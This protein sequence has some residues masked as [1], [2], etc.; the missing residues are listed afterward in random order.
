[1]FCQNLVGLYFANS[2][3]CPPQINKTARMAMGK[4][5]QN[6]NICTLRRSLSFKNSQNGHGQKWA[7]LPIF[8]TPENSK[9]PEWAWAYLHFSRVI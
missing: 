8:A 2:G 7:I 3:S 4:N 6:I 1:M 9:Q 5:E